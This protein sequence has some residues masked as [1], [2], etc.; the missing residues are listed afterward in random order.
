MPVVELGAMIRCDFKHDPDLRAS[1]NALAQT[2]FE[3][4]FE[5]WY[6]GGYWDDAYTCHAWVED[7]RVQA[8]VGASTMALRF[9]GSPVQALQIG[10]VMTHPD[11]RGRGLSS[12]LMEAALAAG[13]PAY[14]F[15]DAE[16]EAFYP[17]FGFRRVRQWDFWTVPDPVTGRPIHGRGLDPGQAEDR[18]LLHRMASERVPLSGR[19]SV[20]WPNLVLWWALNPLRGHFV[21]AA[22]L[23]LIWSGRRTDGIFHLYEVIAPHRPDWTTLQRCLP[24]EGVDRV[25]FHFTPDLLVPRAQHQPAGEDDLLYVRGDLSFGE[26]PFRYPLTGQ[27]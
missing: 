6:A 3:L 27:A 12:R 16:A 13:K 24:L 23:N 9:D 21:H 10:T 4:D 8:T 11:H 19:L 14:L 20:H 15:A 17:R 22:E 18:I 5:S 1:F 7:G 25:V 26:A 2:V